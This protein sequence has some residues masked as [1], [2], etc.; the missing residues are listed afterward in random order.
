MTLKPTM[1]S[2]MIKY[3]LK[4]ASGSRT[5]TNTRL[6]RQRERP[7]ARPKPDTT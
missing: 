2:T 5:C 7:M 3:D 6:Y 4:T 1:P